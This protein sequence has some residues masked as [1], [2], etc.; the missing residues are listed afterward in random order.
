VQPGICGNCRAPAVTGRLN[1]EPYDGHCGAGC[2]GAT[3]TPSIA[4]LAGKG[5]ADE[6]M[7]SG[8]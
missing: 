7:L 2:N 5:M 4:L 6:K 3:R 8:S 1:D